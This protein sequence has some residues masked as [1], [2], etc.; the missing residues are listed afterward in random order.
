RVA[1]D[2]ACTSR[3]EIPRARPGGT[4]GLK[5]QRSSCMQTISRRQLLVAGTALASGGVRVTGAAEPPA[6]SALNVPDHW[7]RA[8]RLPLWPSRPPGADAFNP[9]PPPADWPAAY[10]RAVATPELHVFTPATRR[11][12]PG[13]LVAACGAP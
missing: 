4:L 1:V 13:L 9:P 8:P 7:H 12:G 6:P 11:K 10:R 2:P 3:G 5:Q